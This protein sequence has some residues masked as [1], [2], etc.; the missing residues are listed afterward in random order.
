[1]LPKD[2]VAFWAILPLMLAQTSVEQHCL[3]TMTFD[4]FP[5]NMIRRPI[6]VQQ[7]VPKTTSCFVPFLLSSGFQQWNFLMWAG[8]HDQPMSCSSLTLVRKGHQKSI[9]TRTHFI[10]V[11]VVNVWRLAFA[12]RGF[13]FGRLLY[14][15][16]GRCCPQWLVMKRRAILRLII[17]SLGAKFVQQRGFQLLARYQ[18]WLIPTSCYEQELPLLQNR[19][20]DLRFRW[21]CRR[22]AL[23]LRIKFCVTVEMFLI[24]QHVHNSL[25]RK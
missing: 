1:M 11:A 7:G 20:N 12:W 21:G 23:F 16:E 3:P 24:L 9:M 4:P 5:Y 19:W 25:G 10:M 2:I 14:A 8:R 15:A 17:G 13:C 6:V 18:G 22:L